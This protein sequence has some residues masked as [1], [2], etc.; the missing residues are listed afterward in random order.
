MNRREALAR[1]AALFGTAI[2]GG[3]VFLSGCGPNEKPLE[4]FDE[5]AISLMDE[6]GETILP[7]TSSSPG[8]K[9]ARIGSF[10]KTIVTDCY[11]EEER[12]IF[13]EGL[14][15]IQKTA[16]DRFDKSFNDLEDTDKYT[17][18]EQFDKEA[19]LSTQGK[20]EHFFTMLNQL[21]VWGYFSSEPGATKALRYVPIPGRYDGCIDY[22][23]GE[24][25]WVY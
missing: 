4:G 10:M 9:A 13:L 8:A 18:I 19:K 20:A 25:A 21:T 15:T 12:S 14:R 5:T 3:Q 17:L 16:N 11:S 24:G 7:S 1:T 22:K 23:E 6:I 2:I